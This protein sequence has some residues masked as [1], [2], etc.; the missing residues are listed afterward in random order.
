[1]RLLF[2]FCFFALVANSTLADF[3]YDETVDGDLTFTN[4]PALFLFEPGSNRVLGSVRYAGNLDPANDFD[5]FAFR[6]PDNAR[7]D[8]IEI[9]IVDSQGDFGTSTWV[10]FNNALIGVPGTDI[11][12]VRAPSPGTTSLIAGPLSNGIYSIAVAGLTTNV[13]VGG[14][15]VNASVSAVPEPSASVVVLIGVAH[16]VSRRQRAIA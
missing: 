3:V 9:E 2:T 4:P 13:S 12:Q 10:L 15:E 6:V 1:M 5:S 8:T 16:V 7:V 11:A 14:Y